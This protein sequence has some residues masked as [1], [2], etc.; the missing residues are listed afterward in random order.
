MPAKIAAILSDIRAVIGTEAERSMVAAVSLWLPVCTGTSACSCRNAPCSPD[1]NSLFRA[2]EFHRTAAQLLEKPGNCLPARS[3]RASG[4]K[5]SLVQGIAPTTPAPIA[6]GL[7]SKAGMISS[8]K[9][10]RPGDRGA[11]RGEQH[12]FDAA[13]LQPLQPLDDLLRRAEQRR[14]VEFEIV[15]IVLDL[16]IALGAGAAR[17]IAD[18]LQAPRAGSGSRAGAP[19][20]CGRSAARA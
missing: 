5:N 11:R 3:R 18:I 9:V 2:R 19:R 14:V 1:A 15:G 6:S 4:E 17:Q 12:V 13:R 16:V 10:R 20:R 8:A 7:R